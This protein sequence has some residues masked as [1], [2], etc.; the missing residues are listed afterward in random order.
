MI[1]DAAIVG[2]GPA[3]LSAA[4]VLKA[5]GK[6]IIWFGPEEMSSKIEKAEKIINY[7]GLGIITGHEL[8]EHFRE[9]IKE[10]D[11]GITNKFVSK[12]SDFGGHFTLLA[13]NEMYEAK[14]VLLAAGIAVA[15]GF[16]GEKEYLGRGVS[17]CATCDG[18]F[19]KG[20]TLAVYCGDKNF[21]PEVSYLANIAEKVYLLSPDGKMTVPENN[22]EI[23]DGRLVKILG[24]KRVEKVKLSNDKEIAVEG[25][26]ILRNAIPPE[27]LLPGLELDGP[28]VAVNRQLHTN[29]EGCFA[30]GDNT[31]RPYQIAK[32]V[33]EG[34]VAAH[35]IL[36]YLA[37][38]A[39][40]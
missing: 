14:T 32:A 35:E 5:R 9:H 15:K 26:F 36:E 8:N 13:D 24:E 29:I 37:K 18:M 16:D 38:R 12:I 25:V 22:V 3:G 31:G 2:S 6:N 1:Y 23:V 21:I 4:T 20:K 30:A 33:G 10:L 19:Y 28:H 11:I 39:N 34:N 7:P 17:Y 27:E 40:S